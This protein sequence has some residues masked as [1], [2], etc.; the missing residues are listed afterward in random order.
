MK[1][2][3]KIGLP[4]LAAVLV[5]W[6]AV[7]RFRT[8]VP[9]AVAAEGAA[10]EAVT[11]PSRSSPNM[12]LNVKTESTGAGSTYR[13]AGATTSEGRRDGP[14]G[15]SSTWSRLWNKGASSSMRPARASAPLCQPGDVT[16]LEEDLARL[17]QQAEYGG[18]AS[19]PRPPPPRP[20]PRP[21]AALENARITRS[22]TIRAA[23]GP[24]RQLEAQIDRMRIR[25]PFDGTDR[26]PEGLPG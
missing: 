2:A 22:E 16:N 11:A 13:C 9:V 15:I 23:G 7:Q 1:L 4:L 17:K 10:V 3:L 12:D 24:G 21:R 18:P 8:S 14:P 19:R 20:G 25:A 5:L 26:H 6:L